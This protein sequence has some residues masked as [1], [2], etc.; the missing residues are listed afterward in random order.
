MTSESSTTRP[1]ATHVLHGRRFEG[2]AVPVDVLAEFGAYRELVVAVAR[3][4]FLQENRGR[5]RVPKNFEGGFQLVVRTIADGSAVLPLERIGVTA[6]PGPLSLFPDDTAPDYFERARD[7]ISKAI[8]AAG[9]EAVLPSAF[10]RDALS[11]FNSFGRTLGADEHIELRDGGQSAVVYDRK[12]RKS[13]VLTKEATYEDAASVVGQVVQFDRQRMTFE[14]L[15]EGSRVSGRIEQLPEDRVRII[16]TACAQGDQLRVRVD[17]LGAHDSSDRL[18]RFVRI[19]DVSYAEDEALRTQLDI[20]KQLATLAELPEGWLDGDGA[21][22]DG[23]GLRWLTDVLKRAE[24][25]GLS[26]PYIYPMPDGR[27]QAEWSYP[28]TEV[29]AE[30]DLNAH[31]VEACGVH[32]RSQASRSEALALDDESGVAALVEFVAG[33]GPDGMASRA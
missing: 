10:P 14:L 15:H 18:M 16:S 31:K 30:F 20:D 4:L 22:L 26:R 19:D 21:L 5:Q 17:G 32:V 9:A 7:L 27:V 25:S 33:F 6:G 23:V 2:H 1:F 28:E 29:S 11:L 12:V 8:A 24:A 13:L 3:R